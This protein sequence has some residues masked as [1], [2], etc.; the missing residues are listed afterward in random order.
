[1]AA[2]QHGPVAPGG[3][4]QVF[5]IETYFIYGLWRWEPEAEYRQR[6]ALA[7]G[8]NGVEAEWP[9]KAR[10]PVRIGSIR[11]FIELVATEQGT[12][13]ATHPAPEWVVEAKRKAE[14]ESETPPGDA[15]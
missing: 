8:A 10:T 11:Q 15:P 12:W 2:F 13:S 1:M 9:Y 14:T 4:A 6:L 7:L 5:E 3:R